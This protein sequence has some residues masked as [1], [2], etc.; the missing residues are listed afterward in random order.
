[1]FFHFVFVDGMVFSLPG[2][3]AHTHTHTH[4]YAHIH[5]QY[6]IIHMFLINIYDHTHT[7]TQY[8]INTTYIL[9]EIYD[10]IYLD[11]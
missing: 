11:I 1:M 3:R 10:F 8:I 7:H 9:P 4:K 5:M 6:I 2:A